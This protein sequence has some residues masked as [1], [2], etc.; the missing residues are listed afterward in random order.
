MSAL[1]A[2]PALRPDDFL[3]VDHLLSDEELMIRDAVRRFVADKVV[4]HAVI[5]HMA[6]LESVVT[7]EGTADIHA[8]V[9]GAA[10]TGIPAFR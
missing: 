1:T 7:N 10:L 6:N 9:V 5:R 3:A 2:A 8:L 4:P